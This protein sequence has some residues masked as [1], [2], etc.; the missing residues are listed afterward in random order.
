MNVAEK[1]ELILYETEEVKLIE[2]L[3]DNAK[4]TSLR[5]V[6]DLIASAVEVYADDIEE[7]NK[8]SQFTEKYKDVDLILKVLEVVAGVADDLECERNPSDTTPRI[9]RYRAR[10]NL[11]LGI[12]DIQVIR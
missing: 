5:N 12:A 9:R 4:S 7:S 8:E 11:L 3:V 6:I 1:N 10:S 2:A